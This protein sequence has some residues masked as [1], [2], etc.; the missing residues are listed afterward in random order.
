MRL[1]QVLAVSC[2]R[3]TEKCWIVASSIVLNLGLSH[4]CYCPS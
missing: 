3:K 4:N 1:V 2:Q